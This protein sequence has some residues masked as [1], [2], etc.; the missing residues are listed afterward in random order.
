MSKRGREFT[1]QFVLRVTPQAGAYLD[2][3]CR[4][5]GF[6]SRAALMRSIIDTMMA[7]DLAAEGQ[8]PEQAA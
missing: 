8:Q 3:L 6:S 4:E 5:G 1:E 7:D 2:S